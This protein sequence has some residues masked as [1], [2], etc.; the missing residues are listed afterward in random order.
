M[1]QTGLVEIRYIA[2][3]GAPGSGKT[4]LARVLASR[5]DFALLRD[6]TENPFLP[7][8]HDDMSVGALQTQ[9]HFLVERQKQDRAE[10][11]PLLRQQGV[12]TDY[13][14]SRDAIYAPLILGGPELELYEELASQ[15]ALG[16]TE[17]DLVIHLQLS[18]QEAERRCV[19]LEP[20]FVRLLGDA[21][22]NFFDAWVRTPLVIVEADAFDP[23]K[24]PEELE[25]LVRLVAD[26]DARGGT[27]AAA[28]R[29][30]PAGARR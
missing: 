6:A 25:D 15:V 3:E 21:Y 8:F 4:A 11:C 12:V 16:R 23:E 10:L 13:L 5:L 27:A 19:D 26:H 9:L 18:P 30:V 1:I 7:A 14:A 29:Y 22:R 28:V 20:A 17:P 2:I 24:R